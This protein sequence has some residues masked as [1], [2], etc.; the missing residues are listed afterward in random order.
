MEGPIL[1]TTVPGTF[2]V[3]LGPVGG[4]IGCPKSML[5]MASEK[6]MRVD[7]AQRPH[8][9]TPPRILSTPLCPYCPICTSYPRMSFLLRLTPLCPSPIAYPI[10]TDMSV[11]PRLTMTCPCLRPMPYMP[12]VPDMSHLTTTRARDVG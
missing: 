4:G 12:E 9:C 8:A 11:M 6:L 7:S 5:I 1:G 10:G 2:R 3:R